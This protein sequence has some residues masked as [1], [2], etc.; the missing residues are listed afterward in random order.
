MAVRKVKWSTKAI[1]QRQLITDWYV[2][3]VNYL[4]AVHFNRDVES[5]VATLSAK[6]TVGHIAP[7]FSSSKYTYYSF[8]FHAKYLVIYRFTSKTIYIQ[9][10]RSTQML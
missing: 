6:P 7:R 3:H 9:A 8:V 4:A 5:V 1:G 2:E 10:L